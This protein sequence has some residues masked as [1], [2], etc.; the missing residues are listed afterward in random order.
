MEMNHEKIYIYLIV[1][2]RIG[3]DIEGYENVVVNG[4]RFALDSIA[5]ES[6]LLSSN[7]ESGEKNGNFHNNIVF[8][9]LG[10][11]TQSMPVWR[12]GFIP[13]HSRSIYYPLFGIISSKKIQNKTTV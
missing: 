10:A 12:G 2:I 8:M 9:W 7:G 5:M 3:M 4:F 1:I 11:C 6:K 13:K